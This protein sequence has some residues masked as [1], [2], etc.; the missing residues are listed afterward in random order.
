[1][2]RVFYKQVCGPWVMI[3]RTRIDAEKADMKKNSLPIFIFSALTACSVW[4]VHFNAV[5]DIQRS[6]TPQASTLPAYDLT[7][8]VWVQGKP[9]FI[10]QD[11]DFSMAMALPDIG[12]AIAAPFVSQNC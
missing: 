6:V 8:G 12:P 4:N 10:N 3:F 5:E 2:Q 7:G 11:F 1:M 9:L